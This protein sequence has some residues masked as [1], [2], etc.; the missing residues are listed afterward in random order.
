ML[1]ETLDATESSGQASTEPVLLQAALAYAAHG[2]AVFP[3]Y[4][5]RDGV[6]SC[7]QG[8]GCEH[9]GKHP[10]TDHGFKDATK[11]TDVIRQWWTQWPDAN[12]GIAT[13]AVSGI[14]IVDIDPKN[15]GDLT[16][17]QLIEYMGACR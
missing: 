8:S 2:W 15:G 16:L 12:I 17:D 11:D 10:H 9:P 13:G 5:A 14:V 4:C 7:W 1:A 6:C 3:V